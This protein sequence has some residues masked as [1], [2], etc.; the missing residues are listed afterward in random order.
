MAD[1]ATSITIGNALLALILAGLLGMVGQGVRAVAGL[2]KMS[3]DAQA[4]G[5]SPSSAFSPGWF[6]VSLAIGFIAGVIAGL[7]LGV[8]KIL[9]TPDDFQL[10]LGIAAAGYTGTDFV[11][12]FASRFS[13]GLMPKDAPAGYDGGGTPPSVRPAPSYPP[14]YPQ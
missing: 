7:S 9:K 6:L 2:K 10:L 1:A 4:K 14:S 3:D 13:G 11:E 12:A 5:V 8:S